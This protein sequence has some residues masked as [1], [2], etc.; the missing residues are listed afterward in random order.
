VQALRM[1]RCT[2]TVIGQNLAWAL[3]YNAVAIPAAALGW[4]PPWVAAAGMSTSSLAVALNA[5][6][7]WSWKRSTC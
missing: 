4:V 3:V 1:A 7:L 2:R 6:R 5:M